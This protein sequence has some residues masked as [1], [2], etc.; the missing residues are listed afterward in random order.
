[1]TPASGRQDHTTSPSAANITRLLMLPRPS[2][3][4]PNFVTT[5]KRPL[6]G[7]GRHGDATDL[8]SEESGLFSSVGLDDANQFEF[9][10]EFKFSA[11]CLRR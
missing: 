11:L 8:G 7:G 2:H 6:V 9:P 10:H 3:P 1:L 5:A 4:A